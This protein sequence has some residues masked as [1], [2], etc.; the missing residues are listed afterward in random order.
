M[1]FSKSFFGPQQAK[2]A[3]SYNFV[4]KPPERYTC[5]ICRDLQHQPVLVSCCGQHFCQGCLQ[6]WFSRSGKKCPYCLTVGISSFV[7][8]QQVRD[9]D[10][11]RVYCSNKSK[12][13]EWVGTVGTLSEH[14]GRQ[15]KDEVHQGF[16]LSTAPSAK[17]SSNP[18]KKTQGGCDYQEIDCP[19][20][21]KKTLT[22]KDLSTHLSQECLCRDYSCE[23]CGLKG[24]YHTIT[25]ECGK[26]GPCLL[27]KDGHYSECQSYRI[28]CPNKCSQTVKR[29]DLAAHRDL[30]PLEQVECTFSEV[31]CTKKMARRDMESHVTSSDHLHLLLT[32]KAL[33]ES[34]KRIEELMKRPSPFS[35]NCFAGHDIPV[36]QSLETIHV[37]E[38]SVSV[39]LHFGCCFDNQLVC[40]MHLFRTE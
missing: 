24:T 22:R 27:H 2:P 29:R 10:D 9:I 1:A 32:M 34:R 6:Q 38:P 25:G 5:L 26:H 40:P 36:L 4:E 17:V 35:A 20:N 3:K 33:V 11:L 23:H 12:G 39:P 19:K 16:R 14:I 15:L 37:P 21:C 28:P 31:G 18:T 7:N 13:C 30:C 8:K